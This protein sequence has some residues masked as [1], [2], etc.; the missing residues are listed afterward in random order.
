MS[1]RGAARAGLWLS[2]CA[3]GGSLAGILGFGV[4]WRGLAGREWAGAAL[5]LALVVLGVDRAGAALAASMR[6]RHDGAV[7]RAGATRPP[8]P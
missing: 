2:A 8:V 4:L 1:R 5:G 6:A 7:A 3:W